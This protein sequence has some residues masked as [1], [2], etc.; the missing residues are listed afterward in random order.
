MRIGL[1]RVNANAG[2]DV[3]VALGDGD[4]VI[5]LA[6]AGRDVEETGDA[7]LAGT[8]QHLILAVDQAFVVQVAVAI[9]QPHTASSGSSSSSSRGNKG[10]GCSIRKLLSAS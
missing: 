8:L 5:P 1:V 4:D 6:L 7:A 2:P 9:D 3:V 10:V